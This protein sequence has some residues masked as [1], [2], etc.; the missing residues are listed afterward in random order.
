MPESYSTIHSMLTPH[1]VYPHPCTPC[2]LGSLCPVITSA[3]LLSQT[4]AS[5]VGGWWS[6]YP[7]APVWDAKPVPRSDRGIDSPVSVSPHFCSY[8]SPHVDSFAWNV[9]LL[10]PQATAPLILSMAS[11]APICCAIRSPFPGA[12]WPLQ[13]QTH[14]QLDA[15]A[16]GHL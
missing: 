10:F 14:R 12:P 13:F 8:A 5:L 2:L 3:L 11:S 15:V 9:L 1:S 6:T 4:S 7:L 16:L